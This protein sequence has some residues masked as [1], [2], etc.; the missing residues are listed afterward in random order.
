[1]NIHLINSV[2]YGTIAGLAS[3]AGIYVI[4]ANE[5]WALRHTMLFI[6]F[7][8][9]VMLTVA[10]TQLLPEAIE[11]NDDAL[12]IV[13]ITLFAFYILEHILMI[14]SCAEKECE[15]HPM[16][17]VGF[18]GIGFHSFLDGMVISVGFEAGFSLGMAASAGVLLHKL[19]VGMNIT[20]LLLHV[21]YG[22]RKTVLMSLIVA[23]ATPVGAI[24]A[25]LLF[26]GV[27]VEVLGILLAASA[28]SFIYVGAADLLAETHKKSG[29][30]NIIL[31]IA[32]AI[33]VYI[34]GTILGVH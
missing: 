14:H 33:L 8:A 24:T 31:V 19:P 22:R 20:A 23:V 10:F 7:A 34:G 17:W 16:G 26:R 2:T 12:I 28:G 30:S 3:V 29:K 25:Y 5:R 32:G 6:S 15:T 18:I 11:A 9:G 13:L 27:S 1:M 4:L 21:G